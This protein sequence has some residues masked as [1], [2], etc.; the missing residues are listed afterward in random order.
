M[1]RNYLKTAW[2]NLVKNKVYSVLNISGLAV[3]MAVALLIGL[4]AYNEYSYDKFLPD[5]QRLYRLQRNFNNNGEI[6]TFGTIS[7]KI[8]EI[9]YIVESDWMVPNGLKVGDQKFYMR[10]AQAQSDFLKMFQ[11]PLLKGNANTVLKDPYSIVLT[12]SAANTLFGKEEAIGKTVRFNNAHDLKVTGI[13]KDLPANSNFNISF[14]VPFS[15]FEQNNHFVKEARQGNFDWNAFQAFVKLKPGA[16]FEKVLAKIKDIQK[17]ETDNL[18]AMKSDVL[19]QPFT[20]WHLY[21]EYKNG[22]ATGGFIEYVRMFTVIGILVLLIACINFINLT[23]ARS[24][25]RAREVGVR[26]VVGSQRKDLVI[27]FLA[28]SFLLTAMAFSLAVVL[29]QLSLPAFNALTRNKIAIPFGNTWFWMIMLGCVLFTALIA[30]S[31]PA[32]YL[33][34]FRPVKVLKGAITA[35]RAGTWP[36]RVLVVLQFSC[37]VTLIISTII[38]Y[39]QIEHARQRPTGYDLNRLMMTYTTEDLVK[40]YNAVRNELLQKGIAEAVTLASSPATD[41]YWHS[42]VAQWPG[43]IAGETVEMGVIV[44]DEHYFKTMRMPVVAGRTFSNQYDTTSVVFNEAAIKRMRIKDPV[45]KVITFNG[46]NFHIAGVVKD[47]LMVSPFKPADPTLFLGMSD[48]PQVLLY[49]L[50]PNISSS[51]AL[52]KLTTIF[53]KYNPAFPYTYDFADDLYAAKF[54]LEILIGKLAGIFAGLA[55]FIS[56]LGLFG[57]A[58]YIAEQ[59]T[60]EIGIRKVLG[61]TVAQLWL[62]LSSD[63]IVLV[64]ISCLIASPLAMYFLQNWLQKYDY[65]ISI[66]PGVFVVAA[67]VAITITVI[68]VSAQAI[69][70]AL[71]NPV[72]SLRSE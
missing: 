32:F 57:L 66:G 15:Y 63:F 31:R 68:T 44:T 10:G 14:V 48:R 34:S 27:Q 22:K 8:P 19:L 1:F 16:S 70:A 43:K 28:E 9:E 46:K 2:R 35:G 37:S 41:V 52:N 33:S 30:G 29:V 62:M 69:R 18:N 56:C 17:T 47:A 71:A 26:K 65:R 54:N 61:A 6:L 25:K 4:W 5:H 39:R 60:K 55:I 72:K 20:D 51:E 24:E 67:M 7:L 11:Y 42:D 58:A 59:R 50:A 40:N 21:N 3:G 12:E 23:T 49:R 64:L 38:I 36:R 45:G 13:L 53:N